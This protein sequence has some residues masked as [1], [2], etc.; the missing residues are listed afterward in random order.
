MHGEREVQG[1][2]EQARASE[3]LDS[4]SAL[5][6][7]L[8]VA[9]RMRNAWSLDATTAEGYAQLVRL[10]EEVNSLTA[11]SAPAALSSTDLPLSAFPYDETNVKHRVSHPGRS[12]D[13]LDSLDPE[14]I[15]EIT[16]LFNKSPDAIKQFASM[17]ILLTEQ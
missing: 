12:G 7:A 6:R 16:L 3:R 17:D 14:L 10:R 11:E 4:A 5:G 1:L 8:M 15:A 9:V 13:E 2:L